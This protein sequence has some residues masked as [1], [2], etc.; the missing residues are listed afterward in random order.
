MS[1][2][3]IALLW[4]EAVLPRW[5]WMVLF[6]RRI[7]SAEAEGTVLRLL[8]IKFAA[9]DY[10]TGETGFK[11]LTRCRE[12]RKKVAFRKGRKSRY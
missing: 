5:D 7:R 6:L 11:S 10:S 2:A 8:A 1:L 4:F 3:G 12:K 9:I